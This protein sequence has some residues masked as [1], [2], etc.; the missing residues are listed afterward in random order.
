M[1]F[2]TEFE[3]QHPAVGNTDLWQLLKEIALN[4]GFSF[5]F[6][7]AVG[8]VCDYGITLSNDINRLFPTFTLHNETHI[9]N[10]CNWIVTLVGKEKNKLTTQDAAL[11]VMA[12]CCHDIGMSISVDY[13]KALSTNPESLEWKRYFK[14]HYSDEA[15]FKKTNT[16]SKQMIRNYV[17][18]N[19]HRLVEENLKLIAWPEILLKNSISRSSLARLCQSHG[20][21][22]EELDCPKGTPYDFRFCAVL[23]RIADI[24]DFDS[25]RAPE[26]LFRHLGL[27][28]PNDFEAHISQLEWMKNRAGTFGAVEDG[29]LPF[30]ASFTNLQMEYEVRSYLEWVQRELTSCRDYLSKYAGTWQDFKLPR[31]IS[32]DSIER[33]GYQFGKFC[34]TLDQDQVLTLFTGENLYGD[35]SIFIRELLQNAFDAVLLRSLLDPNFTEQDGK[36]T[37]FSWTDETGNDWF[38]IEDNGVGMDQEIIT[39]FFLKVGRSYYASDAFKAEKQRYASECDYLPISRFG[40]G[41]LSCFMSDPENTLLEVSTKRY[42]QDRAHSNPAIRMNVTGLHGYYYLAQEDAQ[43]ENDALFKRM[44]HPTGQDTGYRTEAGTTICVQVNLGKSGDYGSIKKVLDK[45][46]HFPKIRV[47]YFGSEGHFSYPTQKE[48][49]DSIYALNADTKG[50]IAVYHHPITDKQFAELKEALPNVTWKERPSFSLEYVPLNRFSSTGNVSGA[51]IFER[52]EAA[53]EVAP[54]M[55]QGHQIPFSLSYYCETNASS[56][57]IS[58]CFSAH[59]SYDWAPPLK[60]ETFAEEIQKHEKSHTIRI[61]YHDFL[62]QI[63][64]EEAAAFRY[65]LVQPLFVSPDGTIAYKG[66]LADRRGL[67]SAEEGCWVNEVLLDGSARPDVCLSRDSIQTFPLETQCELEI[68]RHNRVPDPYSRKLLFPPPLLSAL[69]EQKLQD[70]LEK[71]PYWEYCLQNTDQYHYHFFSPDIGKKDSLC[72]NVSGKFIRC[73]DVYQSMCQRDNQDFEYMFINS[74]YNWIWIAAAKRHTNI[75]KDG[76]DTS[77]CPAILFCARPEPN[78]PLGYITVSRIIN[79][80]NSCHRFSRWFIQY[81]EALQAQLPSIY[82]RLLHTMIYDSDPQKIVESING[83]LHT[84]QGLSGNPYGVSNVLFLEDS[85]LVNAHWY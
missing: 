45:Y 83:L 23:L 41:I 28:H 25:S 59:H 53:A 43:N 30:I 21:A 2:K 78:G 85:D 13:E 33:N 76:P 24:L 82:N 35:P 31:E 20:Q 11:L 26:S 22:L 84:L 61:S 37:V 47:D 73:S 15:E 19:H 16:I 18:L 44:H 38:R 3:N 34:M 54:I 75:Y 42:S 40:I 12:A 56:K 9:V 58:F 55:Y 74:L 66:I 1:T 57:E 81:Q 4:E 36:V 64:S 39:N 49:M 72:M 63:S 67:W 48:L 5:D 70:L 80:F 50:G 10:V 7:A 65:L 52:D 60:F 71:H 17:R 79:Y 6:L 77:Q 62:L 51:A 46:I 32:T 27:H 69:T 68:M 8:T 14:D 29:V